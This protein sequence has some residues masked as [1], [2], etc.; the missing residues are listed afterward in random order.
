MHRI[1]FIRLYSFTTDDTEKLNFKHDEKAV[2]FE[3]KFKLSV[4]YA[5][6]NVLKKF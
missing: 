3:V 6:S 2:R 4:H 5:E 1:E